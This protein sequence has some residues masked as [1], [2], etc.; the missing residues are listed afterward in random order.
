MKKALFPLLGLFAIMSSCGRETQRTN[1]SPADPAPVLSVAE[2]DEARAEAQKEEMIKR[3]GYL[4]SVAACHDCHSPKIMTPH[5][6]EPDPNRLLS[7]HPQDEVLPPAGK[8][9]GTDGWVRF[10]MGLTAAV[11]PWGTSFAANLTPDATGTGNWTFENFE[12]A[13]R[14][15]K[16]KGLPQGRDLLPPMPW[17]VYQ[18]FTDEDL[19]SIFVYI[20]S[21]PPIQ[22]VVP[23]PIPPAGADKRLS[24]LK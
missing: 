3:G 10:N 7:G 19:K 9:A 18:N 24:S 11:G 14:K 13:I 23:A 21:L 12:T 17:Q 20:K 5:G 16:F 22:N 6:P 2:F 8:G 1:G 15:G 4:V